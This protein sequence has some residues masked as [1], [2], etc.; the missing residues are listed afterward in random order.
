M[1]KG[2]QA[3]R[4]VRDYNE[5]AKAVDD[6]GMMRVLD[7]LMEG[8]VSAAHYA[9]PDPTRDDNVLCAMF[10]DGSHAVAVVSGHSGLDVFGHENG[11]VVIAFALGAVTALGLEKVTPGDKSKFL[12]PPGMDMPGAFSLN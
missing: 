9:T 7:I 3:V 2:Q 1:T 6:A 5:N 10:D 11:D 8:A 12:P 4:A